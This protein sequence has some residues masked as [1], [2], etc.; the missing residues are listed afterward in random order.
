MD[1]TKCYDKTLDEFEG[2]SP[3]F[4]TNTSTR[5][6]RDGI[7]YAGRDA[8]LRLIKSHRLHPKSSTTFTRRRD[9]AVLFVRLSSALE[10]NGRGINRRLYGTRNFISNYARKGFSR[11]TT[12]STYDAWTPARAYSH[13]HGGVRILSETAS[14]RLATPVTIKFENLRGSLGYDAKR[15]SA[16]FSPVWKGGEWHLR[17]ITNYMT[18]TAFS[19]LKHSA[20]NREKWLSRFYA[21]GKE[22]VRPRKKDELYGFY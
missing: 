5:D 13:Y 18:T 21:I 3:R 4:I 17:D 15:E 10:P 1:I 8:V 7:L 9:G 14:A 20:D 19:L 6:N 11:I 22:A 2:R 12:A 16:N